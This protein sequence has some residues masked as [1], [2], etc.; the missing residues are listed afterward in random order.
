MGQISEAIRIE[1]STLQLGDRTIW[2]DLSLRVSPGEFLT[3]IGPNGAGKTSL[4]K[5]LLGLLPAGG[6][7]EV[8]G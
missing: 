1:G 3:V 8:L 5:V 4:L 2:R 6:L 7:I